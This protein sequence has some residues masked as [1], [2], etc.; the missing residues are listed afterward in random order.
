MLD[1]ALLLQNSTGSSSRIASSST[2]LS[3]WLYPC[4][5]P[6]A[7]SLHPPSLFLLCFRTST[8]GQ[9]SFLF[10]VHLMGPTD[11]VKVFIYK[12]STELP[13]LCF[14][15]FKCSSMRLLCCAGDSIFFVYNFSFW[16][17]RWQEAQ[18]MC[19]RDSLTQYLLSRGGH[20]HI[21]TEQVKNPHRS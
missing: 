14:F 15:F 6:L 2:S 17:S 11:F 18:Y 8:R 19:S 1:A 12:E 13:K 5:F 4:T 21:R 7:L 10:G 16:G 20:R 3:T 9:N